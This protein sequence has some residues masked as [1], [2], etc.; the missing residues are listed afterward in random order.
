VLKATE[1]SANIGPLPR[2]R[3]LVWSLVAPTVL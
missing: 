1:K 2:S 3:P